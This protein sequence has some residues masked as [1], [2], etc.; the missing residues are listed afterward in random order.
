MA[1]R[2]PVAKRAVKPKKKAAPRVHG[3]TL[4]KKRHQ[5]AFLA[6]FANTG[7]IRRASEAAKI[8]R[9]LSFKWREEDPSGFGAE[10]EATREAFCDALEDE[11]RRRAFEGVNE[12]IVYQG[13][14][15]T[16]K[17]GKPV[18]IKRYSDTLLIFLM[19]GNMPKKY[20]DRHKHELSGPDGG[21]ISM[22]ILDMC[23]AG[24]D[25]GG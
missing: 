4:L 17:K 24:G 21:R 12:P 19:K 2:K 10:F 25:G 8:C 6:N 3:S 13:I 16:D 9:R 20:G 14:I 15:A 5:K 7:N 22:E 1:K 11:A 18:T 23:M